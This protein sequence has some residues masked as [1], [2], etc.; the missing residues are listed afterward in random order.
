MLDDAT[1][2]TFVVDLSAAGVAMSDQQVIP[3]TPWHPCE[4]RRSILAGEGL[5]HTD[6]KFRTSTRGA[7]GTLQTPT[8]GQRLIHL[9]WRVKSPPIIK[10]PGQIMSTSSVSHVRGR[11]RTS[12]EA[13]C[14]P[15]ALSARGSFLCVDYSRDQ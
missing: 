4:F 15:K 7:A 10:L 6:S 13:S 5:C 11:P 12:R 1:H 14:V 3:T 2:G 9:L 8:W